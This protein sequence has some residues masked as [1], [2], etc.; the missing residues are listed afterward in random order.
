MPLNEEGIAVAT[1]QSYLEESIRMLDRQS[2]RA[3]RYLMVRV[4]TLGIVILV[5][6]VISELW[7]RAT[8]RYVRDAR[9]RHQFLVVRRVVVANRAS[10]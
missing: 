1:A 6:L 10:R 9:R 7:R 5:V 3:G 4:G 2:A 8:F